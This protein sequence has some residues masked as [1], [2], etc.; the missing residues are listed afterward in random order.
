MTQAF[1]YEKK[2]AGQSQ[3][4]LCL[5]TVRY[6]QQQQANVRRTVREVRS[7]SCTSEVTYVWDVYAAEMT[8]S[9]YAYTA[10]DVV[11]AART[12]TPRVMQID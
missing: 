10:S 7:C 8:S 11:S 9:V 4:M 6:G 5:D 3:R 1:L 12:I 2:A